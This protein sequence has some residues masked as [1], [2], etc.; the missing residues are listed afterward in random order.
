[1]PGPPRTLDSAQ[2]REI[3]ALISAGASK[4]MA[5]QFVGCSVSTIYRE[6]R[7]DSQFRHAM[8]RGAAQNVLWLKQAM[9]RHA[10]KSWH[11]AAWLLEREYPHLYG[12]RDPAAITPE[13]VHELVQMW[14][15]LVDKCPYADAKEWIL[16][17]S[18]RLAR[19]SYR[20]AA[21]HERPWERD[22]LPHPTDLREV[23]DDLAPADPADEPCDEAPSDNADTVDPDDERDPEDID[24]DAP[25]PTDRVPPDERLRHA[26]IT[27]PERSRW[28]HDRHFTVRDAHGVV[29]RAN[30]DDPLPH[31]GGGY[32]DMER[33]R[34]A[35]EF[36]R[37][38]P[39]PLSSAWTNYCLEQGIG[40]AE[41]ARLEAQERQRAASHPPAS[42]DYRDDLASP[43]PD[44]PPPDS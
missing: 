10:E 22:D 20:F 41:K 4:T 11:A 16:R 38:R 27:P 28:P 37:P 7:R 25:Q 2:K 24:L 43:E 40:P 26:A 15:D 29:H 13:E 3:V 19:H 35:A 33:L 36:A 32:Y 14:W 1:M 8:E 31:P 23:D 17:Q 42:R 18:R 44:A 9:R 30:L 5:A 12:R 21:A 34:A 39:D 6:R